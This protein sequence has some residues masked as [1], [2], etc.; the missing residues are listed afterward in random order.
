M[1]LKA[2]CTVTLTVVDFASVAA[3][4]DKDVYNHF[5]SF[6]GRSATRI[7]P[8]S[9]KWDRFRVTR[10]K[11]CVSVCLFKGEKEAFRLSFVP[12]QQSSA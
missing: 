5:M 8:P 12:P 9:V 6:C 11:D 10:S 3:M 1:P 7:V 4:A 2:A